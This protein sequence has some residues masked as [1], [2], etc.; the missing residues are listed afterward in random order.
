MD[1]GIIITAWDAGAMAA[2]MLM[3]YYGSAGHK[4]RW[5]AIGAVVSA[6]SC[7]LRYLPHI[8]FGPGEDVIHFST[9]VTTSSNVVYPYI[10]KR[11]QNLS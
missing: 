11:T 5:V 6:A 4:T 1:A 7:Y 8:L 3:A 9:N 2:L 10:C